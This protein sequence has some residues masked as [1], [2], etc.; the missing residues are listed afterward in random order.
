[1]HASTVSPKAFKSLEEV[2]P[3]TSVVEIP[4]HES[5]GAMILCLGGHFH[6]NRLARYFRSRRR[7]TGVRQG[8]SPDTCIPK[9][10]SPLACP[11]LPR[12]A[13]YMHTTLTRRAF[14]LRIAVSSAS[15]F[16]GIPVKCGVLGPTPDHLRIRNR[17]AFLSVALTGRYGIA[18][19]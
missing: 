10:A 16:G 9:R 12:L 1:M 19:S 15:S 2:W 11:G 17:I 18:K 8:R 7:V 3:S 4:S 13:Q 14:R 5:S 6:V